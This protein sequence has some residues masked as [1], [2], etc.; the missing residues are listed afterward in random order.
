[1]RNFSVESSSF[2]IRKVPVKRTIV[3]QL[4]NF[5]PAL[6]GTLAWL[7]FVKTALAATRTE[8]VTPKAIPAL[9]EEKKAM[10]AVSSNSWSTPNLEVIEY[11]NVIK[12]QAVEKQA[13]GCCTADDCLRQSVNQ[14]YNKTAW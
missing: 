14:L 10:S 3:P 8:E 7:T 5:N 2:L 1:M 12:R 6:L 4:W 9:E 11:R 13:I